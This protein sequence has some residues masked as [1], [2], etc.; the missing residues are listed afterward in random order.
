M[1]SETGFKRVKPLQTLKISTISVNNSTEAEDTPS[2]HQQKFSFESLKKK[3][4]INILTEPN[5]SPTSLFSLFESKTKVIEKKAKR[6]KYNTKKVKTRAIRFIYVYKTRF[7]VTEDS[8]TL[9]K[10]LINLVN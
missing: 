7:N 2:V 8:N 4:G 5:Q 1:Q 10:E 9:F 3:M 6:K